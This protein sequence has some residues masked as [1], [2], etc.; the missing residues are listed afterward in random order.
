VTE[1][2]DRVSTPEGPD[3]DEAV[4]RLLADLPEVTPPDGFFDDLIRT[5]R[6]RAR[7]VAAAGLAAAGVAGAV[8]VA[9]VTGITGHVDPEMALLADRHATVLTVDVQSLR[10][11]MEG[12]EVPAPYQ[13]PAELGGMQRG[14]AVLH[15][16]DV[17]QVVYAADGHYLSVFEQAGEMDDDAV[18][19]DVTPVAVDGVDAW[20]TDDGAVIVRRSD[21]VYVLMGDVSTLS[22]ETLA[23]IVAQLPDAR[24]LG[25]ARRIGDA[26]DDL[27][28]AFGLR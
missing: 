22:P 11:Q 16:D 1:P 8:V 14:M 21:V 28:N 15:P 4:R 20:R 9:H 12:D 10:G 25:V 26:M 13:A 19:H 23:A 18:A 17:V 24:R 5:R 27:V 2:E 7:V 3:E 6:R